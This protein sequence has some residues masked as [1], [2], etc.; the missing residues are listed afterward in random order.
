[1]SIKSLPCTNPRCGFDLSTFRTTYNVRSI[2]STPLHCPACGQKIDLRLEAF[3]VF[4]IDDGRSSRFVAWKSRQTNATDKAPLEVGAFKVQ[5][6]PPPEVIQ[7]ES[8]AF[9][10]VPIFKGGDGTWQVPTLPVRPDRMAFLDPDQPI[11]PGRMEHHEY[12]VRLR[13]RGLDK[14]IELRLPVMPADPS[15]RGP[16]D[17]DRRAFR[18][19]NLRMWPKVPFPAWKR[20]YLS[21][22][23]VDEEGKKLFATTRPMR[24]F[25]IAQGKT[26]EIKNVTAG[27]NSRVAC[28]D[29][30]PEWL[31]LEFKDDKG[32]VIGGGLWQIATPV[33]S[34]TNAGLEL[35]ADFGTSNT[36]LAYKIGSQ[37]P[38]LIPNL[39]PELVI[40]SGAEPKTHPVLELWIPRSGFGPCKDLL[41]SELLFAAPVASIAPSEDV[42]SRLRPIE[43]YCITMSGVEVGYPER[44]HVVS[45]LK[46]FD[47]VEPTS[48]QD[49]V[50]V[51][52]LQQMYLDFV[53]FLSLGHI[54]S[55]VGPLGPQSVTIRYSFPLVFSTRDKQRLAGVW[56]RVADRLAADTGLNVDVGTHPIDEATAAAENLE[57]VDE[58]ARVV[59][60]IGGGTTDVAMLWAT[61]STAPPIPCYVTSFRF[62]GS[63]VLSAFPGAKR[64]P[65]CFLPTA[66]PEMLRRMIRE[67]A[68]IRDVFTSP[69][70]INS[71]RQQLAEQRI[72]M[73][74][75][76]LVEYIARIILSPACADTFRDMGGL[77]REVPD[78]FRVQI[79]VMGNGWGFANLVDGRGV[80][81]MVQSM[82]TRRVDKIAKD[83]KGE[84]F[85]LPDVIVEV[86]KP[87]GL[88]HPKAAVAFGVLKALSSVQP[89]KRSNE[90]ESPIRRIVG[91]TTMIGGRKIPWHAEVSGHGEEAPRGEDD[92]V[93]GAFFKWIEGDSPKFPDG[94][95]SPHDL[96]PKLTQTAR[97]VMDAVG[98]GQ[99]WLRESPFEVMLR[100]LFALAIPT[101]GAPYAG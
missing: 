101:D 28:A 22:G 83:L 3:G 67:S 84:P 82:V 48:F 16:T 58:G 52:L 81:K 32:Q 79:V 20:F 9:P 21:L 91:I 24:A 86:R 8:V 7:P 69:K 63:T 50:L 41:A 56:R 89:R 59:V 98:G 93:P 51:D 71:A 1:M 27:G 73:F 70:I 54:Y 46:W 2:G 62:A 68:D 15:D 88:A 25:W 97:K 85:K 77:K 96:D 18:G 57:P 11:E 5:L 49:R 30:R 60:D 90:D 17:P 55:K 6:T 87:E 38:E 72:R 40:A 100:E 36:A 42:L 99:N 12:V 75:G 43:D 10:A 44:E 95:P 31:G 65:S 76:Y 23:A 14:P 39:G 66:T 4:R 34:Y 92:V 33:G 80:S 37:D 47:S 61:G 35:G 29:A 45:G 19:V 13:L 94:L 74:F 64:S 26:T 53:T 78:P